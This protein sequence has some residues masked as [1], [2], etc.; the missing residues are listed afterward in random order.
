MLAEVLDDEEE[1]ARHMALGAESPDRQVALALEQAADI[2]GARG[3]PD[4]AALLLE[5][6]ARLT[7]PDAEEVAVVTHDRCSRTALHGRQ[8][9]TRA[10]VARS[11]HARTPEGPIRARALAQLAPI[12]SDD[13]AVNEAL[14][15]QALAEAG[16][17]HR[18]RSEI[19]WEL[20]PSFVRT[21][22]KF[23]AMLEYSRLG[24]RISG[25]GR[26]SGAA[27]PSAAEHAVASVLHRPSRSSFD[28]LDRAVELDDRCPDHDLRIRRRAS[29]PRSCSGPTT[30]RRDALR[31][32]GR[33]SARATGGGIR[34]AA[35]LFELAILEWYAGNRDAAERHRAAA[36]ARPESRA[37]MA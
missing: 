34:H 28:A 33:W 23:A 7:P 3:A 13:G 19:E 27:R 1:R 12:R 21:A 25:V 30:T 20:A 6:A 14:L 5:D 24:D 16:D 15:E 29:M 22:A 37:T 32:R 18:L 36:D 31:S 2:A 26:R 11:A 17:H 9:R 8:R 35:L 10:R 4:S